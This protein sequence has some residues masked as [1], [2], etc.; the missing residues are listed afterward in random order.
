MRS[1]FAPIIHHLEPARPRP[2]L[3]PSESS[4]RLSASTGVQ[5]GLIF[6]AALRSNTWF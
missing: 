6:L 2:F 5:V 3:V 1:S 4:D